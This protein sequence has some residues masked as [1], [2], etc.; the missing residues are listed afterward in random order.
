[1]LTQHKIRGFPF[2]ISLCADRI[3]LL[4]I[5][6]EKQNMELKIKLIIKIVKLTSTNY[7]YQLHQITAIRSENLLQGQTFVI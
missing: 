5:L 4:C 2:P 1:M 7:Q 3:F 6:D